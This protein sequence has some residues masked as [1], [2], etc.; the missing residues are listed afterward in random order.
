M[1]PQLVSGNKRSLAVVDADLVA[2]NNQTQLPLATAAVF[3]DMHRQELAE[4]GYTVVFDQERC[5]TLQQDMWDFVETLEPRVRCG[6][7]DTYNKWPESIHRILQHHGVGQA[8]FSWTVRCDPKVMQI[9]SE[10]HQVGTDELLCSFDGACLMPR[11]AHTTRVGR[12]ADTIS[13]KSH[14]DQ[15]GL[16]D[17]HKDF[18][19]WKTQTMAVL[20]VF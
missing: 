11:L 4:R 13:L 12:E 7:P 20:V 17:V 15:S 10:L 19:T 8:R 1:F 9:F 14:S 5:Q 18:S 6:E 3:T 16:V 2:S